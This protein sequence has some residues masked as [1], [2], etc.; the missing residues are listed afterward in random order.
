MRLA[1][2]VFYRFEPSIGSN[3]TLYLY[4]YSSGRIFKTNY[5]AYVVVKAIDERHR[6]EDILLEVINM[7]PDHTSDQIEHFLRDLLR[8]LSDAGVVI[9]DPSERDL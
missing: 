9:M 1:D 7:Y 2:S 6:L 3:G 5:A 8:Q 4:N